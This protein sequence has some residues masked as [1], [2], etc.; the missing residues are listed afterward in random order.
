MTKWKKIGGFPKFKLI[1]NFDGK[2]YKF[3]KGFDFKSDA[4]KYAKQHN[5]YRIIK[6]EKGNN[7]GYVVYTRKT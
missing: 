1:R 3:T 5:K 7:K 6:I 4:K 2:R